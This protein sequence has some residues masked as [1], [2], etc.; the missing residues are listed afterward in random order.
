MYGDIEYSKKE[1]E[2]FN[3]L[4]ES[5][6]R[7]TNYVEGSVVKDLFSKTYL[8]K[9]EYYNLECFGHNMDAG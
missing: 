9:V 1:N 8:E 7:G 2:F 3:Y 5:Y 4:F 6:K